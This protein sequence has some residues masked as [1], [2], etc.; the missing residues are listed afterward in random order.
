VTAFSDIISPKRGKIMMK[1]HW[2]K[3]L[4]GARPWTGDMEVKMEA[5]EQIRTEPSNFFCIDTA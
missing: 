2:E 5:I 1:E 3:M 4:P